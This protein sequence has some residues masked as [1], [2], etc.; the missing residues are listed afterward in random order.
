MA[1]INAQSY[2]LATYNLRNDNAGDV[3]DPW[4]VRGPV[5]ADLI[6]FYDFDIFGT[7]EGLFHQLEDIKNGL[8][9]YDYIGVGRD[10][11]E[12]KGEY[13]AI[14]YKTNRFRLL[15]K[16]NFWLSEDTEKPNMG[17]D[18]ACIRICSWG[19]FEEIST[20]KEFFMF[21]IHYDHIGQV[22]QLESSKLMIEKVRA[23]AGDFP[24]ILTG[25]FNVKEDSRSYS[26]LKDSDL[27][28]DAYDLASIRFAPNGTFNGFEVASKPEGRIDHIFLTS[29]FNVS[30]YG[31]LT[32]IYNG[33]CPSDHFP[34]MV[35]VLFK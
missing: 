29:A 3:L 15:E 2:K 34:V 18:A 4:K 1:S 30:R 28:E 5:V 7:Q 14:F 6:R 10:D 23:I 13:S 9:G 20:G 8:V 16:G 24:A 35:D 17:W 12:K 19:K 22:A 32:N 26:L 31:I 11:G 33:R 27:F 21:N 25:D